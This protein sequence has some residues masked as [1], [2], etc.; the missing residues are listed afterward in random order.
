M[1]F[2]FADMI[3][4]ASHR[5]LESPFI[6]SVMK[7]PIYTGIFV[8]GIIML[9]VVFVYIDTDTEWVRAVRVG[10][11]SFFALMGTFALQRLVLRE[12]I[13]NEV[14]NDQSKQVFGSSDI[15]SLMRQDVVPVTVGTAS[16]NTE[17]K[18][19]Y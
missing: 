1:P 10:V 7:N 19:E 14:A 12:E 15:T 2:N 11:W 9:I 6:T 5:A 13:R 8:A 4:S 16:Q 17:E 18:I 3:N